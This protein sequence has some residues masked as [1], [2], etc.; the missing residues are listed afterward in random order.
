MRLS[1]R[2][3]VVGVGALGAA[4]G[5]GRLPWQPEPAQQP[6]RN[7]PRIGFLSRTVL[8][9]RHRAFWH[10]LQDLGYADGENIVVETRTADG[11]TDRLPALVAE[12]VSLRVDVI[13]AAAD[14][15][16]VEVAKS[17]TST[18]PIVMC[19]ASD[20]VEH[21]LVA[22]FARP[23]G[24]VTGLSLMNREL[25]G[26][27]LELLRDTV[28]GL[29]RVAVL[30]DHVPT[31]SGMSWI[32][33]AQEAGRVLGLKLMPLEAHD[34]TGIETAFR[35]ASAEGCDALLSAGF[36]SLFNSRARIV[37]LAFENRLP[38]MYEF[39]EFTD[40]GGL[41]AYG[42]RISAAYHR[43][44]YY[45]DRI[46]KGTKPAD[47]PVEQPMTFE[48]VV[49]MRTARALGITFPHEVA[50]QITEVIE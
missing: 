33:A 32:S 25:V 9:E 17:I 27:R 12:L 40:A 42:P 41:M 14:R 37:E 10:G 31:Q 24:N 13:V 47:L 44:A 15:R 45:V 35:T 21:G 23:G 48:F 16:V 7:L 11:H 34:A 6:A 4:T 46:L 5:C 18:I 43:A 3:F 36:V 29:S 20:P 26:K 2:Q 39:R 8:E 30:W 22:S 28:P 49:N 38:S 19:G 1:R 50:L